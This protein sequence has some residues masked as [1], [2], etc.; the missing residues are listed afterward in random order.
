MVKLLACAFKMRIVG[1]ISRTSFL[2]WLVCFG[3]D[4][5]ANAVACRMLIWFRLAGLSKLMEHI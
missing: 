1:E 3:I 4:P 5:L 2:D